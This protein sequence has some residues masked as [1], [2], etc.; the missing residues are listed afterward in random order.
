MINR[1]PKLIVKNNFIEINLKRLKDTTKLGFHDRSFSQKLTLFMN[2][3]TA[4]SV[5]ETIG[6][7]FASGTNSIGADSR[8]LHGW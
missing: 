3:S 8:S 1:D 5:K 6:V 7:Q 2:Q 4:I